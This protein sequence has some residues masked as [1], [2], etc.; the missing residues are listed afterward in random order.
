MEKG[1]RTYKISDVVIIVDDT[2]PRNSWK[3]GK[4]EAVYPGRDG[5]I[6]VV[7]VKTATG[8]YRRPVTKLCR[9]SV[10]EEKK[11]NFLHGGEDVTAIDSDREIK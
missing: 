2:A 9:I 7:D 5:I 10:S 1:C 11:N 6:R 3:I 4:I 8:I